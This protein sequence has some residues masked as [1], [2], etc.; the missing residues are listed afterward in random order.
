[1]KSLRTIRRGFCVA[2]LALAATPTVAQVVITEIEPRAGWIE[3]QNRGLGVAD[4]SSWSVHC[5]TPSSALPGEY[6]WAF[7]VGTTLP[8]GAFLRV[9]WFATW[10]LPTATELWTGTNNRNFLFGL[11]GEPLNGSEGSVALLATQRPESMAEPTYFQD[12]VT[13]G[14]AGRMR[15]TYAIQ[16]GLWLPGEA[17]PRVPA[18]T[19][20]ALGSD[21][22][23]EPTPPTEFFL[24][25]TPSPNQIN[26]SG[27]A[28]R[29]YGYDCAVG[30]VNAP[31]LEV[32]GIPAVGNP[33]FGLRV[34]N[35]NAVLGQSVLFVFGFTETSGIV[36]PLPSFTCP[37][38]VD[39]GLGPLLT[40]VLPATPGQ[41]FT[42][43]PLPLST[44]DPGAAGISIYVQALLGRLPFTPLDHA[45]SGGVAITFG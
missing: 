31:S 35:T 16:A 5:T 38:W 2:A 34:H 15:E 45:A 25:A 9:H 36:L 1:M 17:L 24:D 43:L 11:G 13:W 7:P 29:H 44:M 42:D 3:I 22:T 21:P 28:V 23:P 30:A 4:L 40:V 18:G 8:S 39:G 41:P 27:A 37:I 12:W 19:S 10:Q 33:D 6:W 20:L 26:Q 32:R 14:V